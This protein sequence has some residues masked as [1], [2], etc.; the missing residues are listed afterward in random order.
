MEI[1]KVPIPFLLSG[2]WGPHSFCASEMCAR[3][4]NQSGGFT[5]GD[6][7]MTGCRLESSSEGEVS[8]SASKRNGVRSKA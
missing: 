2:K 8:E 4:S 1:A 6:Q 3:R 7:P 5:K